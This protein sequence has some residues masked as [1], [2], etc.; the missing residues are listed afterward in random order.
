M[1]IYH[2]LKQTASNLNRSWNHVYQHQIFEIAVQYM[3]VTE[4]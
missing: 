1:Y 3:D 2:H 4:S